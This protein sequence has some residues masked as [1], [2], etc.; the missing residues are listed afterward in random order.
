MSLFDDYKAECEFSRDYPFGVPGKSW[1]TK[2]GESI[3]LTDMTEGHIKNCMRLVGEDDPWY[4]TFQKELDRRH[5][6]SQVTE[7]NGSVINKCRPC[8]VS[9][10][11][12]EGYVTRKALFHQWAERAVLIGE[13]PLVGGHPSG[14]EKWTVGI[15]EF[16]DGSVQEVHPTQITFSDSESVFIRYEW[17]GKT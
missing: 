10:F 11:S 9:F 1:T 5:R 15:V 17:R 13:S 4:S 3:K 14:V 8:E 7:A 12:Q 6:A 16:E 2:T